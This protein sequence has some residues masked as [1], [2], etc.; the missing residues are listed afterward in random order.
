MAVQV[1][2]TSHSV[3]YNSSS[4]T[5][6]SNDYYEVEQEVVPRQTPREFTPIV[7]YPRDQILD[8]DVQEGWKKI[9]PDIIPD[10]FQFTDSQSLNMSTESRLPEDFLND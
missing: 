10:H 1:E 4:D 5:N 3:Q 7:N 8:C 2:N 6:D 9:E